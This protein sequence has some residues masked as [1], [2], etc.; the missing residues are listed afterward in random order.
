[1]SSENEEQ[2]E[3]NEKPSQIEQPIEQKVPEV[4]IDQPISNHDNSTSQVE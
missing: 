2:S 3:E 4:K 1:M